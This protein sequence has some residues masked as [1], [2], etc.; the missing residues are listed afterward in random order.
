M[1]FY[2]ILSAAVIL[3]VAGCG[4]NEPAVVDEYVHCRSLAGDRT[5]VKILAWKFD[6]IS[7]CISSSCIVG[8]ELTINEIKKRV[9]IGLAPE[10]QDSLAD[11]QT[12]IES[13]LLELEVRG[14]FTRLPDSDSGS[15]KLRRAN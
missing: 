2:L 6:A 9:A 8:E 12:S 15:V 1:N 10:I 11:T 3:S 4:N 7:D 13:T 5:A 14:V